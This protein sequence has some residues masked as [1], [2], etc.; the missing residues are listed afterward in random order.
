MADLLITQHRLAQVLGRSRLERL[1]HAGWLTPLERRSSQVLFSA[2]DVHRALSKLEREA[3]PPDRIRVAQVRFSELRT[4]RAY[5]PKPPK[6]RPDPL[7]FDN[8]D[9]SAITTEL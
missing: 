7:D 9:L 3:C 4:G 1:R 2:R 5:V 6:E 8:L